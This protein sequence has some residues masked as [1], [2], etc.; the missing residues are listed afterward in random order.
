[1]HFQGYSDDTFGEVNSFDID[2]DDCARGTLRVFR[3]F[4]PTETMYVT[5]QYS[6]WD[7]GDQG[8]GPGTWRIGVQNAEDQE[9]REL[10]LPEWPM[11]FKQ[12]DSVESPRLVIE[13][14]DDVEVELVH[15]HG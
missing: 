14:P 13:A 6:G 11:Y 9:T 7:G 8:P 4:T 12:S 5:G 15:P 1:L 10:P 3:V 2:H